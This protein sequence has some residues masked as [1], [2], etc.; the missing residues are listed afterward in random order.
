[1]EKEKDELMQTE[2]IVEVQEEELEEDA[3]PVPSAAV[4]EKL[5]LDTTMNKYDVVLLARRWAYELRAKQ[6]RPLSIQDLISC[7]L[8]D[9]LSG[10]VD[11]A[12]ILA[13]P[14]MRVIRKPKSPLGGDMPVRAV[15]E[16]A[17]ETSDSK[18]K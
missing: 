4:V 6:S 18:E 17:K 10:K 8:D 3:L 12:T 1:M 9:I 5:V 15:S 11:P 16:H 13:L 14:P 7:A 2:E